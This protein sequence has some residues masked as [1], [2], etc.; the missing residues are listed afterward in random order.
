MSENH[1]GAW[2]GREEA[3][4]WPNAVASD[5]H[6]MQQHFMHQ[7][8]LAVQQQQQQQQIDAAAVVN[9]SASNSQQHFTY[10]MASSFQNPATTVSNATST[11]PI[12]AAGIRGYDYGMTGGNP[13]MSAPAPASQWWYPPTTMDSIQNSIQNMQSN[14]AHIHQQQ[15][16]MSSGHNPSTV[17]FILKR[18][19]IFHFKIFIQFQ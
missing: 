8:H 5:Q 6:S 19:S 10:K 14:M 18:S 3:M 9:S 1:P 11:S 2:G 4:W 15:N 12:G 16:N 17:R 7:Q 13:T